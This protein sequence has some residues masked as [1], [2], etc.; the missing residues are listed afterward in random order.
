M[1]P[2]QVLA[3]LAVLTAVVA[4]E[5]DGAALTVSRIQQRYPWNGLVD[6]DYTIALD[7]GEKLGVDDNL[8]VFLI[9]KSVTP[10]VTNRAVR[11]QQVPLPMS[12]GAHR[13]TWDANADG[14]KGSFE[15]AEIQVKIVRYAATYMVINVKEGSTAATYPVDFVTG[16][17]AESFNTDEFKTDKIVLR[18]IHRGAYVAGSPGDEAGRNPANQGDE[19]QHRVTISKPFYI[20][21][22]EVT[23]KQY[24]NVVGSYP[25]QTSIDKY[26]A[27]GVS[28]TDAKGFIGK[29]APKCLAKDADG[30]YTVA[31]AGFDL[32]TEF[33][34]EYACRAGTTKAFNGSDDFDNTS[35]AAQKA[36]LAQ[37]GRYKPKSTST[38]NI[39][40]VVGTYQPNAWGLYDMHGN[41]WEQCRDYYNAVVASPNQYDVDP[42][43]T[44]KTGSE[45]VKRGGSCN[46]M[47]DVCRSALRSPAA[48]KQNLDFGFRL[49]FDGDVSEF[50]RGIDIAQDLQCH[51]E[52][53]SIDLTACWPVEKL[54]VISV[55]YS[56]V[57]WGSVDIPGDATVRL[58]CT[59]GVFSGNG[60]SP[61]SDGSVLATGLSGRGTYRWLP[62]AE[63]KIY[64][65]QHIVTRS[66][67]SVQEDPISVYYDFTGC[68]MVTEAELLAAVQGVSQPMRCTCD[69]AHPWTLV[70]GDGDG[71]LNTADGA[72]LSFSFKGAGTFSAELAFASGSVTVVLD[73]QTVET[74]TADAQGAMRSWAVAEPGAH[75]L[76]LTYSGS[77][78]ILVRN[79]AHADG[80]MR[81]LIVLDTGEQ[82]LDLREGVRTARYIKEILPFA[83]SSRKWTGEAVG[84]ASRVTVVQLAGEG[85]DVTKWAETGPVTT[86]FDGPG[87]GTVKW[88]P[89]TGVWKAGLEIHN[90]TTVVAG[91]LENAYFDL[92]DMRVPGLMLILK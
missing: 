90:G 18:R 57:G 38:K 84:I 24:K 55:P 19:T 67:T 36:Q 17:S 12:A 41:V 6:I 13:I 20:G 51:E 52:E 85:A 86:L 16:A 82:V 64:R 92:R 22:F 81:P 63:R 33:Q 2:K 73:G 8:E 7:Q 27:G 48:I 40:D 45:Y 1:K 43:V 50:E 5:A 35:E 32:P 11:F 62:V 65:V 25:T 74:V 61:T 46:A 87:E 14:V 53:L 69:V 60:F 3:A 21:V 47:V 9:D 91:G 44:V 23:A 30:Q 88:K 80:V 58:T 59:E 75:T 72:R 70:G 68:E 37:L 78:E 49:S 10:A 79:C 28:W 42:E 26:P 39:L 4:V 15:Q 34:W 31:L 29:L 83:Y 71:A 66:G 77:G 89:K 54:G 76:T 56:S